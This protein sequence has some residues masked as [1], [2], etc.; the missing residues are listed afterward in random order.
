MSVRVLRPGLFDTIQDLGRPGYLH[1]GIP[2]SGAMDTFSLRVANI[3]VGN[4]PGEAALEVTLTGPQL[5]FCAEALIG[6]AGANLTAEINNS[7]IEMWCSVKVSK[8]DVLTFGRRS[9]GCRAYV[10]FQGGIEVPAVLG[11]KSTYLRG[12]LGGLRGRRL[13]AGDEFRLGTSRGAPR[14]RRLASTFRPV[15]S[16]LQLVRVIPGPQDDFFSPED[17]AVF[18]AC[19]YEV[20]AESDR[21]GYRLRGARLN[22]KGSPELVSDA[23]VAGAVQ[24]PGEGNPII[25][26]ADRQTTGGYPKIGVVITPDLDYVSQLGPGDRLRF[27]RIPLD[28]AHRIYHQ[29]METFDRIAEQL[30]AY[31]AQRV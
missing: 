18:Y 3:L 28:R 15:Y 23:V 20:T 21:M 22:H 6:I 14:R 13:E 16:G 26:M 11:S 17:L 7:R 12:C 19:A 2:A 25:L 4:D 27:E 29:Y 24:I 5:E 30:A 9:S 1:L 31:P 10:A 8:G